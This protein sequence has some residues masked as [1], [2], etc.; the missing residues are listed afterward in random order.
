MLEWKH[1]VVSTDTLF[2]CVIILFDFGNVLITQGYVKYSVKI[3]KVFLHG[4][5][6]VVGQDD[7]NAESTSDICINHSFKM[8]D[9]VAVVHI[10]QFTSCAKF[11]MFQ[12]SH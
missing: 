11:D 5:E 9:N 1:G 12:D 3:G 10:V 7:G 8:L 2:D 4:F 6:L